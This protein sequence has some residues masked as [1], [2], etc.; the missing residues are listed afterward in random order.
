MNYS[1]WQDAYFTTTGTAKQFNIAVDG[2]VIYN[3]KGYAIPGTNTIKINITNICE[4]YLDSEL[5]DLT[6]ITSLTV[7]TDT[8]RT[9]TISVYDD[10]TD[11]WSTAET[12]T[13]LMNYDRDY[14]PNFDTGASLNNV[15]NGHAVTGMITTYSNYTATTINRTN[16]DYDF[17]YC[18]LYALIYLNSRGGWDS[19]LFEGKCKMSDDYNISTLNKSYDNNTTGFGSKRYMNIITPKYELN[20]GWLTKTQGDKFAKNV[21][22]SNKTYLQD[23][24]N[25]KVIPVVIEDSSVDYKDNDV[26]EGPINYTITVKASQEYRRK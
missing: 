10:V 5:P 18:G 11:T 6:N 16:A 1:I 21:V 22:S 8:Y 19:F 7:S 2:N 20:T 17:S 14:E 9:F 23:I 25:D 15:V 26:Q 13:Y 3:G 12:F 24:V 4:N